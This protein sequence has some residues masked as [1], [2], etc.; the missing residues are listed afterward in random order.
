MKKRYIGTDMS[1]FI[2]K[3]HVEISQEMRK[4]T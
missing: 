4:K 3:C 2:E 1:S